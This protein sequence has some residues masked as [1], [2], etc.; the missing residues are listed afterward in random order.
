[1]QSEPVSLVPST[2][3]RRT[4]AGYLAMT[5]VAAA[6]YFWIRERGEQL[7]APAPLETDS[8]VYG[9]HS[10][11]LAHVLLALAA[12]TALARIVGGLVHRFLRQPP[13]I[14]EILAGLMLG[15]SVLGYLSPEAYEFLL[16]SNVAPFLG[17]ISKVGV[18]LFM[19][20]VG[21]ELDPRMLRGSAHSTIAVSHASILV[22]FLLGAALALWLYPLY[23]TAAVSFTSFSLFLGVSLSVTAFPVL[24]R[25]LRD[26]RAQRTRLGVTA[27][28][29]AAV[30]DVSAW[31]LLAIV[32]GIA[33]AQI[34]GAAWTVLYVVLYV[35]AML[36]IV[37][38]LLLRWFVAREQEREGPLSHTA[39]A[40]VFV[41]LLVSAVATEGIGIHALFGAF[42]LGAI[43]PHDGRLPEQIRAKLE[44]VVLV[45]FLPSFFAF[46]GMRTS[47]DLLGD[48][49]D[50]MYC[51]AI[52]GVATV[53]KFGGSFVAARLTGMG[54]RHSAA[55]GILMNTRGLMELIVLNLGLDLGVI[56]PTVFTMMVFMALA[57]T[58]MTTPL[59][60][61]LLGRRGF[62]DP[63]GG[64]HAIARTPP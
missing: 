54:W 4:L 64:A 28:A 1:M 60:D 62:S 55:L 11:E 29:C 25:I 2:R 30:D 57:T 53:G 17:V 7:S 45:L 5:A 59:L 50:W 24:A 49:R 44:D 61:L 48:S 9:G 63:T 37:R 38:P 12:I 32:A 34:T 23:S 41:S 47:I 46:T 27:L 18:V 8:S 19:F 43:L 14:G 16:P 58:F 3:R 20:L 21:L 35:L 42:L 40:I 26:R 39:L 36:F 56:T 33:T 10:G 51:L 52:I 22:P 13:V 31:T 15:P 6:T